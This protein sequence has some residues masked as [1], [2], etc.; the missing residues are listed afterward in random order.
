MIRF[1]CHRERASR[2]SCGPRPGSA[3]DRR[4]AIR[5]QRDAGFSLVEIMVVIGII[6]ILAALAMPAMA[7]AKRQSR[8]TA[9]ANDLR[10]FAAALEAYAQEKGG[11]PVETDAADI[12]ADMTDRLNVTAWRRITPIG[13]HYNWDSNQMHYGT[14]YRAAIQISSTSDAPLTQDV[15]LWEALDRI[16]DNGDLMTGNFRLGTD[17]EPIFI[18]AP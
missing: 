1:S 4:I 7:K 17:D 10:V 3:A 9:V 11:F 15:D 13:G 12:P 2:P 14:H 18:I 8:A 5:R 6:S 16:V